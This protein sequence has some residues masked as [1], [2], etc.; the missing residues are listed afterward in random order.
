M[1]KE[2]EASLRRIGNPRKRS[3]LRESVSQTQK[4]SP[5]LE[6]RAPFPILGLLWSKNVILNA[7]RIYGEGRVFGKLMR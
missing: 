6:W 5:D 2:G 7:E 1:E 4:Y 3:L